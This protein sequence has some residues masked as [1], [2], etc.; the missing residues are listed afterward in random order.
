MYMGDRWVRYTLSELWISNQYRST[1]YSPLAIYHSKFSKN[2]MK[3]S[4]IWLPL[5]ISGSTASMQWYLNWVVDVSSG[6]MKGG[7]SENS[8]EGES[9]TLSSGASKVSC[10]GCSG[11]SAAGSIGAKSGNGGVIKWSNVNSSLSTKTTLRLKYE[12]GRIPLL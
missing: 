9:A 7:P 1:T 8:Y 5:T 6:T 3:S 10:S 12:V 4:Y 11:D 2:L